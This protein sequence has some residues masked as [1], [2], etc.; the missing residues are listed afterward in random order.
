[1]PT[2]I[3][4]ARRTTLTQLLS[5]SSKQTAKGHTSFEEVQSLLTP[6][7]LKRSPGSDGI[8]NLMLKNLPVSAKK[9]ILL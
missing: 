4:S 7:Q 3:P 2:F 1:M 9:K 6:S 5:S 8:K